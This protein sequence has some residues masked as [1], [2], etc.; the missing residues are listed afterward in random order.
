MFFG[1]FAWSFVFVSLPFHIQGLSTTDPVST[2]R[3]TGWILGISS[4]VTVATA[5]FWGRYAARGDPKTVYVSVEALQGLGFFGMALARTLPEL[6]LARFVLGGMGAASTLAYIIVGRTGEGA[7]V[8]R[9]IATLQSATTVGQ[10]IGPLVGAIAAARVGFRASFVVGGGILLGCAAL[11]HWLVERPPH[12]AAAV[13]Q[14]GMVRPREVGVVSLIVLGGSIHIFFFTAI[15]PRVLPDFGV[16]PA[17]TLEIG[18]TLIFVSGVAAALGALAVP[19]LAELFAEARL[20][21]GLLVISSLCLAA[22]AV[23]GSVW[24]YGVL[25][26]FQVLSI[27]PVFPLVVSRV[28]QHAGGGAIGFINSARIAAGFIG[29]VLATTLLTWAPPAVLYLLLAAIGLACVPLV[30]TREA[31]ARA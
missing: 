8:R 27:A 3:W 30:Q 26:F 17:E 1:S 18:G 13:A 25:R 20:I 7:E 22:F 5:P 2:L 10:V 21:A 28:V 24:V 9:R 31:G 29:P 16:G 23:A 19:R 15:L 12:A 4:L 6:F 14:T 11:V